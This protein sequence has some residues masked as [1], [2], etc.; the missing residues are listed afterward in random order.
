MYGHGRGWFGYGRSGYQWTRT[1]PAPAGYRY[2]GPCRCGWGPNAFYQD[3]SGRIV[4][5]SELYR[6]G[7]PAVAP[8]TIQGDLKAELEAL[9]EEKQ[10]L[11]KRITEL[12]KLAKENPS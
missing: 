10:D 3:A 7:G 5:A 1:A 12:E 11:E 2:V 4:H 8:T 6:W 9:K